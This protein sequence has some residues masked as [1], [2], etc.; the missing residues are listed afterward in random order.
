MN[1]PVRTCTNQGLSHFKIHG[2]QKKRDDHCC[3]KER[4]LHY[5]QSSSSHANHTDKVTDLCNLA[6][7][8]D[9]FTSREVVLESDRCVHAIGQLGPG[10][11]GQLRQNRK[12]L[13]VSTNVRQ[14][15][16]KASNFSQYS[17]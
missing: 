11:K 4:I 6:G 2:C 3:G 7:G 15:L 10:T 1:D 8:Q 5:N 9:A 14:N 17:G 12:D 13:W 16:R